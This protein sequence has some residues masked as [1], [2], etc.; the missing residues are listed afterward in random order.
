MAVTVVLVAIGVCAL[1]VQ[2]VWIRGFLAILGRRVRRHQ[3]H[4]LTGGGLLVLVLVTFWSVRLGVGSLYGGPYPGAFEWFV[5]VQL[6]L[7]TASCLL[8]GLALWSMWE[9]VW[10]LHRRAGMFAFASGFVASGVSEV[11]VGMAL[12]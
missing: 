3:W 8:M 1:A 2:V 10:D 7:G 9:R 5:T 4:M 6:G 11:L 12:W